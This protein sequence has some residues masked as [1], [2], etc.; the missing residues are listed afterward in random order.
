MR[1]PSE[2]AATLCVN[3]V[4][5]ESMVRRR[6]RFLPMGA[7]CAHLGDTMK[8]LEHPP[9]NWPASN[10]I[11]VVFLSIQVQFLKRFVRLASPAPT[12]LNMVAMHRH[13][14]FGV[15]WAQVLRRKEVLMILAFRAEL[16]SM[17]RTRVQ[18]H[19]QVA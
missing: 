7:G 2:L 5:L 10:A 13:T 12:I 6:V 18:R 14:V 8:I 4:P 11:Q 15:R 1:V 19:V 3:R 9:F 17:H 16:D